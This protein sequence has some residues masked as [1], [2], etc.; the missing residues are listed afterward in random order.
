LVFKHPDLERERQRWMKLAPRL[1]RANAVI[2]VSDDTKQAAIRTLGLNETRVHVVPLGV[3]PRFRPHDRRPSPDP[4]YLLY[5]GEY[6][7]WKGYPEACAAI[8]ELAERGFPH[9][10]KIGG[11]VAEWVMPVVRRLISECPH[12][13]RV[14][15][16]G[17]VDDAGL[18]E[19]YS[20]AT[21]LVVTSRCEGFGLPAL[22]AMATGTPVIAFAN[23]ATTEV[24]E[25]GG[26]LV[27][28]GDVSAVVDAVAD[29]I[30]HGS[31][32]EELSRLGQERAAGFTWQA[33]ATRHAEIYAMAAAG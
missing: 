25:G 21:A 29:V 9:H 6:G 30:E 8:S 13:E 27:D 5:V 28:D 26:V 7:P 2:A 16:L 11:H 24:V 20:G 12:P 17:F 14:E 22:E 19:L 23:S 18:L 1:A 4:P 31:R 10:L 3:D 15:L 32:W 33:C